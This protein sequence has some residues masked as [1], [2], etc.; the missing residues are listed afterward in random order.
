MDYVEGTVHTDLTLAE[1]P[2]EVRRDYYFAMADG[3]AALHKVDWRAAG[4]EN[5]GRPEAYVARQIS[6]WT[7]QYLA[8]DP[9]P[10]PD[11][12]ALMEWL[13]AHL[14]NDE[15]AVI[16]H[17]DFRLGNLIF[18]A[19]EPVLLATLDWELATIGHPLS[20]LAYLCSFY[21]LSSVGDTFKGIKGL[22]LAAL[23][24]PDEAAMVDRYCAAAGRAHPGKDWPFYL[25]F[26]LFRSASIGQGVYDRARRGNAADKRGHLYLGMARGCSKIGWEIAQNGV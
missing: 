24:I 3:L 4:L 18:A 10:N 17:G 7:K 9:E 25:A 6:R 16:A 2:R 26:S 1:A 19:N 12:E 5:F 21:R 20:D 23:G 15:A 13:P 8:S 11:M 22:D 14:P